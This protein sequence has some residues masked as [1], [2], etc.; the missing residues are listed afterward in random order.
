MSME[1]TLESA[2]VLVVAAEHVRRPRQQLEVLRRQRRHA[3]GAGE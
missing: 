2:S 1:S 3:I